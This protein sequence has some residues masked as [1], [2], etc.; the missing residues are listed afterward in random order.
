MTKRTIPCG[1][2][3]ATMTSKLSSLVLEV[4]DVLESSVLPLGP[5]ASPGK[6]SVSNT[7]VCVDPSNLTKPGGGHSNMSNTSSDLDV[8]VGK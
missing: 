1:P 6:P 3:V 2:H 8:R 7:L 5:T 4:L